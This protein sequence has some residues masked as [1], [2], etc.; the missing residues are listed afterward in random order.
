[1]LNN[2]L[3]NQLFRNRSRVKKSKI[4]N[5]DTELPIFEK[6]VKKMSK[7]IKY[8][9]SID[10]MI[11]NFDNIKQEF[12]Y[13]NK[14][15]PYGIDLELN[16]IVINNVDDIDII[17]EQ[18]IKDFIN[19]RISIELEKKEEVTSPF[20]KESLIKKALT[21]ALRSIEYIPKDVEMRLRISELEQELM[22]C[23]NG[24]NENE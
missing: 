16:N 2:R 13:I 14:Y 24:G 8:T 12:I 11:K 18:F 1:M 6:N 15:K 20:L 19:N 10:A 3:I 23:Y 22:N 4:K 7:I 17:K 21:I 9:K 5:W